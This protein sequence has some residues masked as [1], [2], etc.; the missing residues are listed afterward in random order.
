MQ[1]KQHLNQYLKQSVEGVGQGELILLLYEAGITFLNMGKVKIQERDI[2]G[3]HNALVRAIN[4]VRELMAS[5]NTERGGEI[6]RNLLSLYAFINRRIVEANSKKECAGIEEALF[7]MEQLKETWAKA[8]K[9]HQEN[10]ASK[11][12]ATAGAE[13][14]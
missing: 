3:A 10:S 4:V 13:R 7:L 1:A 2:E 8:I 12:A 6:A 14:T 5:L 11:P 9:I